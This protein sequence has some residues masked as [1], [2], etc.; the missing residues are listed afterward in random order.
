MFRL[1][2]KLV[3][4]HPR[5]VVFGW[6]IIIAG[7]HY[8]A[9][10]WERIS[11]DDDLGL[12]P[13]DYPSVIG[14][15][16]LERGF[17]Q[18]AT[19]SELVLIYQRKDGH[20]TPGDFGFVDGE[21]AGLSRLTHEHP[22]LG[23]KKID[24][25]RSPVIGP[26]LIGSHGVDQVALSIVSLDSGYLSRKTQLAVDRI[27]E[28]V[29]T[30]TPSPPAGLRRAVTGSAAVGRDTH[31]ATRES[32]EATTNTTIVLVILILLVVYRSVL[33]AMVP[34]LTIAF[35][36]FASLRLIALLAGLPG[37]GLQV[38]D[39]SQIF[40]V[41]VL[42]GAGIDYCL[43]LGMRYREELGRGRSPVMAIREA[44]RRVGPAVVASAATVIVGLGMLGFS[45]FATFQTTGPT[46]AL[47]LAV[48]LVAALTAAPA[49]LAWPRISRF[50]P[51]RAP[52]R[53]RAGQREI[54]G[55]AALPPSGF[56]VG[57]ADLVVNRPL[58]VFAACLAVLA[59][60]AVAGAR[61]PSN[62]SQLVDL[63]PDRPSVVGAHAVR[64]Y[65]A[66]GE[67]SPTVALIEH[68]TLDFRSTQGR[69]AIEELSRRLAALGG[70]AEVRSSTRPV[71]KAEESTIGEGLFARWAE[72]AVRMAA[73]ARYVATTPS[74][75]AD[76]S[77]IA[78]L[79]IVFK[80][81]PFAESSLPTLNDVRETLR[82]AAATG[83]PLQGTRA[84]GLAGSTSELSD[85]ERVTTG[86]QRRMYVLVTLGVYGVLVS[87]L[88]RPG[89]S[90]YLVAT[91]VLGYLSS[92]GLTDLVFRALHRGPGPWEGLDWTVAFFLF[93]I[94]VAVGADFNILLMTRVIEEER[95][96]GVVE[97][98]RR[99]VAHTGG[100]I[101]SCGL[102][103][104]GTFGSMLTGS[105][106]SLR[107]LGFAL[108]L[109]VLL[110][111]FLVRPILVPA[112]VI[113]ID[114]LRLRKRR[115]AAF[116]PAESEAPMVGRLTEVTV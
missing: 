91:V 90:L 21:A 80:T 43:F 61:A 112:V 29:N 41:V 113:L 68:P 92:L 102:I 88:R 99:A 54:E 108:G 85:L 94:L 111:T 3:I 93:V 5:A 62:Y 7:L 58:T 60:L 32:I 98:T 75:A 12:F 109:G 50:W 28:S 16:L 114:R 48:A 8:L 56:W 10:P 83:Q 63:D 95:K 14:R 6:L 34:L 15:A 79:E 66:V 74:R 84:I 57:V 107:E 64:D 4:R 78:R 13:P 22:E 69:A 24:T 9:P 23:I 18:D 103:M 27:L 86:D 46:I 19:S 51:S 20:L 105:L 87:L 67:L 42:F 17:P 71:G 96:Y 59:P 11:K 47:S 53:E 35:S 55:R 65:F 38:V 104:A 36:A 76:G 100:I 40:V 97:G 1:V 77:H 2:S 39:I 26:R 44:I 116:R 110:D 101:S 31:A 25:H 52:H 89:I 81:D 30:P 73:E 49:M 106:T 33:L 115:R 72:R 37:L 70:V 82:L 45:R